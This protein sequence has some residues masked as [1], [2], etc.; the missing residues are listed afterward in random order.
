MN[1]QSIQSFLE[2]KLITQ[3][4]IANV[5][6]ENGIKNNR[7]LATACIN[8]YDRDLEGELLLVINEL[9]EQFDYV[10]ATD[11]QQNE[12]YKQ[13]SAKQIIEDRLYNF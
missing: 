13:V 1:Q 11:M 3:T 2:L 12:N 10:S 9:E 6:E 4:D 5:L 8:T 7:Q